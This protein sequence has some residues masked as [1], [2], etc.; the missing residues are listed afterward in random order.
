[1][2]PH[3]SSPG[4]IVFSYSLLQLLHCS[5]L[6]HWREE[7]IEEGDLHFSDPH[8]SGIDPSVS[9]QHVSIAFM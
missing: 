1:V 6:P 7:P 5:L 4:W 8:Y 9:E 2:F 3:R